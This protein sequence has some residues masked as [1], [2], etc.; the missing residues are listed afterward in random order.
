MARAG[1]LDRL[2]AVTRQ[3][4]QRFAD[5]FERVG[6]GQYVLLAAE[7][8]D[9]TA[10]GR[11]TATAVDAIRRGGLDE[12]A[13]AALA[14]FRDWIARAYSERLTATDTLLLFQSLPD[15]ADDR[16]R[17]IAGLERVVLALIAWDDL[18][19]DDRAELLGPWAELGLDDPPSFTSDRS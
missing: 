2:P 18:D 13:E 3:R 11:A 15:R 6:A 8:L 1:P 5:A 10:T 4:L 14:P 9:S 16:V 12:A 7:P 19:A 17:L